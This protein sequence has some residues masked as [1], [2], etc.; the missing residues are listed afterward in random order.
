MIQKRTTAEYALE[1]QILEKEVSS[2]LEAGAIDKPAHDSLKYKIERAFEGTSEPIAETYLYGKGGTI[3]DL[4][5]YGRDEK[6]W[7]AVTHLVPFR[8]AR[9][10]LSAEKKLAKIKTDS[11]KAHPLFVAITAY[12]AQYKQLATNLIELKTK[13][14]AGKV[15]QQ[16]KRDAAEE[17]RKAKFTEYK[18]L[19]NVLQQHLD[20][21]VRAAG[22][23]AVEDFDGWMA[24]MEN[25]GWDLDK[26]APLP[27]A[28]D[29]GMGYAIKMQTRGHF[30]MI[31]EPVKGAKDNIR[32]FSLECKAEYVAGEKDRAH[33]SYMNW[34]FKMIQKI[35]QHV[36]AAT[37]TGDP[38]L[39]SIVSVTCRDGS[40]QV[41]HTKM[42]MNRSKYNRPFHQFPSLRKDNGGAA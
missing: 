1:L 39:N 5:K 36:D 41:W 38:W 10:L 32:Q 33:G 16:Q 29:S 6:N 4:A 40:K 19:V 20:E 35:G 17:A 14:V 7:Y 27:T 2:H 34:I 26:V 23:M 24:T 25:N 28:N 13:V 3:Y 15:R 9:E 12:V 8:Y 11:L 37:M 22:K 21:Y 30:K 31:T 42:K 18:T